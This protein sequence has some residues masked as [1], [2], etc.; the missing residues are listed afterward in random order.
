MERDPDAAGTQATGPTTAATPHRD[1][2]I[3]QPMA[4]PPPTVH[5]P[6]LRRTITSAVMSPHDAVLAELHNQL[7]EID[8]ADQVLG[9][10]PP[11]HEE[12]R[13][14]TTADRASISENVYD[15]FTGVLLGQ[16]APSEQ[17][18]MKDDMW[19]H[20]TTIREL[21]SEIAM[22]HAQ[23]EGLGGSERAVRVEASSDDP[24]P[25][26]ADEAKI[27]KEA[28]FARLAERFNGRKE[29]INAM[30]VKLDSLSEAVTAFH[31]LRTPVLDLTHSR[32]DGKQLAKAPEAGTGTGS[33][34]ALAADVEN[35]TGAEEPQDISDTSPL[36]APP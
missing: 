12:E 21:Q 15:P 24:D 19:T 23:M 33:N 36:G 34:A 31:S 27:A 14:P 22:M 6:E 10:H 7:Q 18:D 13:S 5:H 3:S 32:N 20:L 4:S 11:P 8:M 30:M 1:R 17:D 29:A 2:A 26:N 25:E 35:T 16:F 9:L 28:E